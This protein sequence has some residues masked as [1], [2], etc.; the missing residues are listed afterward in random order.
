MQPLP[1]ET[2]FSAAL[3][4]AVLS[5]PRSPQPP[6]TLLPIPEPK[7]KQAEQTTVPVPPG[8]TEQGCKHLKS[9]N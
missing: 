3:L 4:C 8:F 2:K 7:T 9:V 6:T 1:S 5:H